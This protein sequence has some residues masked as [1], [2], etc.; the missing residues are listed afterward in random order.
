MDQASHKYKNLLPILHRS[1]AFVMQST[2]LKI[3]ILHGP[4]KRKAKRIPQQ[5][6]QA[7]KSMGHA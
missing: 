5:K 1:V 7:G 2:F 3:I 6:K 4:E